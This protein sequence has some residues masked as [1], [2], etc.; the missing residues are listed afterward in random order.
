MINKLKLVREIA[1]DI[2]PGELWSTT[3]K[4]D[5]ENGNTADVFSSLVYFQQWDP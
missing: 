2:W 1:N 5:L 4:W 3:I